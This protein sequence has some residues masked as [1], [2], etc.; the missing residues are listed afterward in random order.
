M[1]QLKPTGDCIPYVDW[2]NHSLYDDKSLALHS[3]IAR[4]IS[5][6]PE[7]L[8]K[9]RKNLRRRRDNYDPDALPSFI[10]KWEELLARISHHSIE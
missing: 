1:T 3:R 7:L 10:E 8:D 2:P 9:A 6:D 4:N 5:K